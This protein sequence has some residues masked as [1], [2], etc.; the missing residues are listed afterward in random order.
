MECFLLPYPGQHDLYQPISFIPAIS[1]GAVS[2]I[3]PLLALQQRWIQSSWSIW[4]HFCP[5][6]CH[7]SHWQWRWLVGGRSGARTWCT[8]SSCTWRYSVSVFLTLLTHNLVMMILL[9][10]MTCLNL[11]LCWMLLLRLTMLW[12][13]QLPGSCMR[14]RWR[15]WWGEKSRKITL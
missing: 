4:K 6:S 5:Q 7:L 1:Q 13:W 12:A 10:L 8:T 2:Q 9:R 3:Q 15:S 14:R 11:T